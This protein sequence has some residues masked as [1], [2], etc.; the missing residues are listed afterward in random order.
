MER[1]ALYRKLRSLGLTPNDRA[2]V[3]ED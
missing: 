1:S 3:N 2:A